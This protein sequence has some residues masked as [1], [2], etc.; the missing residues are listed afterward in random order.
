[1]RLTELRREGAGA[2][3]NGKDQEPPQPQCW[4]KPN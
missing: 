1:V 4:F 2:S 3:A